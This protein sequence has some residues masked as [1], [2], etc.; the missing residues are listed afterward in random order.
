MTSLKS[1]FDPNILYKK[2]MH[3][4]IIGP[5]DSGKSWL[6]FKTIIPL[7]LMNHNYARIFYFSVLINTED[8]SKLEILVE[9]YSPN[10]KIMI[11]EFN[12]IGLNN[13]INF[14]HQVFDKA[15]EKEIN[16]AESLFIFNDIGGEN[17]S[18]VMEGPI[19]YLRHMNVTTLFLVQYYTQITTIIRSNLSIIFSKQVGSTRDVEALYRETNLNMGVNKFKNLLKKYTEN[20]GT[21]V[22]DRSNSFVY[23]IKGI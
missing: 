18:S 11:R 7:L 20:Y 15:N 10:S 14:Y 3:I 6:A 21:F 4:C 9:R 17:I 19:T 5:T 12:P 22:F 23:Y 8:D 1:T 13:L 2:G 16:M